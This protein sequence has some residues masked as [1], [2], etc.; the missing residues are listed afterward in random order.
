MRV[1]RT[2][3]GEGVSRVR[4][5]ARQHWR[6]K[7]RRGQCSAVQ[8][9]REQGSR[10]VH[11]APSEPDLSPNGV[12]RKEGSIGGSGAFGERERRQQGEEHEGGGTPA[13][14][15]CLAHTGHSTDTAFRTT[16]QGMT[17]LPA[18]LSGG[19][20]RVGRPLAEHR[21]VPLHWTVWSRHVSSMPD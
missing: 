18:W 5:A 10:A 16:F 9:G 7:D 13:L 11:D 6:P 14:T 4:E 20:R 12:S 2:H 17:G 3:G 8:A 15:T 1:G 19:D 21:K